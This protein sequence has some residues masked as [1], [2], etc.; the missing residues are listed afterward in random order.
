MEFYKN[1]P[2]FGN[3]IQSMQQEGVTEKVE[4]QGAETTTK[5]PKRERVIAQ[6]KVALETFGEID[7][8]N[9]I[10]TDVVTFGVEGVNKY[11]DVKKNTVSHRKFIGVKNAKGEVVRQIEITPELKAQ[12]KDDG[13]KPPKELKSLRIP[14]GKY[15]TILE[16][17]AKMYGVDPLR[18]IREQD[19]TTTQRK[20]SQ[21]YILARRDEHIVSLPEGT[22][23]AGDPTGIATTAL[24]KAFFDAG[25][26]MKFKTT[27]TGKGLKEQAKQRIDPMD[28]L[29]IFGLIP[30]ARVNSTSVDPALRSQVIQT[31]V[32]A[33]NQAVRQEKDALKLSKERVDKLK[34]GK[35]AVMYSQDPTKTEFKLVEVSELDFQDHYIYPIGI[36][37]DSQGLFRVPTKQVPNGFKKDGTPKTYST[38]DLDAPFG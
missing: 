12:Y 36:L 26:R 31:A 29:A 19:L 13:K 4:K 6:D 33:I 32:I 1:D 24:G 30:K 27:G 35:G 3:I 20:K 5:T 7:L 8:Q 28:Y 16:K 11:L 9:E 17:V 23:R 37:G 10:R 22:T 21:D 14:T 25:G 15:Y 34:D 2:R 38:R 18:L